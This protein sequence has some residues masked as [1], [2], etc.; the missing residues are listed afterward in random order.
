MVWSQVLTRFLYLLWYY[1]TDE[2]NVVHRNS[3]QGNCYKQISS[4]N[5]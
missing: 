4:W 2:M 3:L 5:Y 1:T